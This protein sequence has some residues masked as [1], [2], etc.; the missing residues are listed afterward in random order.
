M[1][2]VMVVAVVAVYNWNQLGNLLGRRLLSESSMLGRVYL[3]YT[4]ASTLAL[5][6]AETII[7]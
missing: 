6:F 7:G 2:A 4:L 5:T 1:A 3:L